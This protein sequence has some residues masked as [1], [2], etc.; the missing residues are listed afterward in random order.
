[1]SVVWLTFGSNHE[2]WM[3]A[4]GAKECPRLNHE[5]RM[6]AR[7]AKECPRL[8]EISEFQT[9][10]QKNLSLQIESKVKVY[11]LQPFIWLQEFQELIYPDNTS[12]TSKTL[13]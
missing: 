4:R 12:V 9:F 3:R 5:P 8:L 11:T 13:D 1:M 10:N 6:R 7:G 2:P